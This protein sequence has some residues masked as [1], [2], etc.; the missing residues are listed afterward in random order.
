M[1]LDEKQDDSQPGPDPQPKRKRR[2][3]GKSTLR[4]RALRVAAVLV[5]LLLAAPVGLV[6]LYRDVAPPLTLLMFVRLFDGHGIKKEWVPLEKISRHVPNSVIALED[7]LFCEHNGFDWAAIFDAAADRIRGTGSGGGSTITQQTAKNVFLWPD[8]TMTRKAFE[9][10][11]AKMM[12]R[13]WGKRRIM[14]V[15]LNVIEWGPG[16]YGIEAASHHYFGKSARALT[17]QEAALLAAVL[18]SPL[19]WSPARPT[20]RVT[21]RASVAVQR[22]P[23]LR[24]SLLAC[25]K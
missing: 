8:R 2:K 21:G 13:W 1:F 22:V 11:F 17:R 18:P 20:E 3:P 19:T 15:Y 6:A 14:E 23:Q 10:P 5:L 16:I 25:V 24:E 12:E 7:N 9:V 4:V